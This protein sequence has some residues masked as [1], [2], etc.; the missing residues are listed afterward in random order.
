MEENKN[1]KQETKQKPKANSQKL[2]E[3]VSFDDKNLFNNLPLLFLISVL[4]IFHVANTHRIEKKARQINKLEKE[5][6]ELRW[7]YM[8]TKSELMF[9]SKQS[10]VAKMVKDLGL[11]ESEKAPAK[12][13]VSE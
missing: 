11:K 13:V 7:M 3:M 5:L 12:I 1:I 6:K 9:Q 2:K 10:E 8:T 4:A